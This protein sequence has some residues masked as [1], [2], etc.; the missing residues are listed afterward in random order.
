MTMMTKGLLVQ[1]RLR[2][3]LFIHGDHKCD[4][5]GTYPIIGNRY[6]RYRG[7]KADDFDYCETCYQHTSIDQAAAA[8]AAAGGGGTCSVTDDNNIPKVDHEGR[9]EEECNTDLEISYKIEEWGEYHRLVKY[10]LYGLCS[11]CPH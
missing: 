5:C 11:D 10:C 8:A 7:G 3:R 9:S 6:H 2:P 1:S 4:S